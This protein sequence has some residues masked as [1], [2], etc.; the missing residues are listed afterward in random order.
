MCGLAQSSRRANSAAG[1]PLT[2][3]KLPFLAF[4]PCRSGASTPIISK[5]ACLVIQV[6]KSSPAA[7]FED[8]MQINRRMRAGICRERRQRTLWQSY[9][10]TAR[11]AAMG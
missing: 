5:A 6:S 7:I 1:K 10:M 2:F 4:D 3:A 8:H 11:G 9:P